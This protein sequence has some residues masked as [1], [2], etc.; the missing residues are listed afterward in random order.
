[1]VVNENTGRQLTVIRVVTG[2][3]H[4]T[5][6]RRKLIQLRGLDPVLNL[7]AHLLR[8]QIRVHMVKSVRKALETSQHLV[9]GNRNAGAVALCDVN[10]V[11]H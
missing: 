8:D 4:G 1:M 9:E 10:V 7:A 2:L 11:S 6:L 5:S 3:H